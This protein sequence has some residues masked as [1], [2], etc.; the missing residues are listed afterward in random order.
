MR[1]VT[2]RFYVTVAVALLAFA[3]V[4]AAVARLTP[5]PDMRQFHAENTT[6]VVFEDGTTCYYHTAWRQMSCIH[7][8]P[9]GPKEF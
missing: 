3:V 5:E 8:E 2:A 6:K 1:P 7:V 9:Y 4:L